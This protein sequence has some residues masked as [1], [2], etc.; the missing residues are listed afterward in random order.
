LSAVSKQ[1]E[2]PQR[3]ES[4]DEAGMRPAHGHARGGP[5]GRGR[6]FCW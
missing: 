5:G 4:A 3:H 6:S 1:H 2:E